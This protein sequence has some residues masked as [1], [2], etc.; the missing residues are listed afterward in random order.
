MENIHNLLNIYNLVALLGNKGS[1]RSMSQEAIKNEMMISRSAL[2]FEESTPLTLL[3]LKTVKY[4]PYLL[5]DQS[6]LGCD[7]RVYLFL[8]NETLLMRL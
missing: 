7:L 1:H 5:S 3:I 4:I 8:S 2:I 6:D